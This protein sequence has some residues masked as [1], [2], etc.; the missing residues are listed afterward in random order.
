MWSMIT[1]V[2][3]FLLGGWGHLRPPK[4]AISVLQADRKPLGVSVARARA[5][6]DG[7]ALTPE[8]RSWLCLPEK[9]S[10]QHDHNCQGPGSSGS[11]L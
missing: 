3:S 2:L 6:T 11:G 9:Q 8:L 10:L 4:G 5:R 1:F 7:L